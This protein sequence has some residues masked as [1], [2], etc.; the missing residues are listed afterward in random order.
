MLLS[1]RKHKV[2]K[3]AMIS[4]AAETL[5]NLKAKHANSLVVFGD[6]E[7]EIVKLRKRQAKIRAELATSEVNCEIL[8]QVRQGQNEVDAEAAVTDY[9]DAIFLPVETIQGINQVITQLGTEQ[10]KTLTKIKRLQEVNQLHGMGKLILEG[11][12]S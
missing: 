4:D 10:I 3:E 1:S 2:A 11:T 9:F 8:V 5:G 7:Q 6:I 12:I